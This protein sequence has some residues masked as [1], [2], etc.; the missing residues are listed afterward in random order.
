MSR[1]RTSALFIIGTSG[2]TGDPKG[3]IYS[4][5]STMVY[6]AEFAIMEPRC[7]NG[8]SI[9][10]SGPY[11]SASGTLL[12]C[13]FCDGIHHLCPKPIYSRPGAAAAAR[14]RITTF[15]ASVIFF[16]RIAALPEFET[17]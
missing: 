11:S 5:G 13:S 4:H 16:E 1:T 14:K 8:G 12:L 17:R 7:G 10:A 9:L 3:V 2:S 15:L 6:A